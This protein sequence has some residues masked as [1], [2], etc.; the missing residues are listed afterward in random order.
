MFYIPK[1]DP[2]CHDATKGGIHISTSNLHNAFHYIT[3]WH[4]KL[5]LYRLVRG[6]QFSRCIS[7]KWLTTPLEAHHMAVDIQFNF[8]FKE[9]GVP[10]EFLDWYIRDQY[11]KRVHYGDKPPMS[12]KVPEYIRDD[13][14][15]HKMNVHGQD[16]RP[17]DLL[18]ISYI[19]VNFDEK[20]ERVY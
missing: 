14:L 13:F 3:D 6:M 9:L 5:M 17:D 1:N 19:T 16:S 15:Q 12:F 11:N 4:E 8:P 20:G 2:R 7:K 18:G 10:S